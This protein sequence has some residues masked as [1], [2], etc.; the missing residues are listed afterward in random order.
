MNDFFAALREL[1]GIGLKAVL[2]GGGGDEFSPGQPLATRFLTTQP[3]QL[4]VYL[5]LNAVELDIYKVTLPEW[6]PTP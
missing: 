5:N 4:T 3:D 6:P 2:Y 1:P